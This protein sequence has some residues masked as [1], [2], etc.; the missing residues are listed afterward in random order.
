MKSE[1]KYSPLLLLL[2]LFACKKENNCDC[3]K[4]TGD[5]VKQERTVPYL[6]Y[7]KFGKGKLN[8]FIT[9]DSSYKVEIEAGNN[10]IDLIK[11]EVNGDTLT[12]SDYNKCNFSRSYKP[13]I[14]IYLSTPDMAGIIQNGVG[15]I[16]STNTLTGSFLSVETWSSGDITLDIDCHN[17]QSHLHKSTALTV[18]GKAANHYSS[19][20]HNSTF[21]GENLKTTTTIVENNTT[22]NFY[23][24]VDSLLNASIRLSGEI[25]YSGN[26]VIHVNDQGGSGKIT[27]KK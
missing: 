27:K 11:T 17:F 26:P 3:L 24:T 13:Q 4:R 14:N 21:F 19:M 20:W 8:C 9:N 1:K 15:T 2:F 7:F 10:L 25:I 5:I 23:C 16:K 18:T 22:G 12:F 6:R